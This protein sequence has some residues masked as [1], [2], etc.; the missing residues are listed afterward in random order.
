MKALIGCTGFVGSN[1]QKQSNFEYKYDSAN[2]QY[3]KGKRFDKIYCAGA[4]GNMF[5]ANR[6][7]KEDKKKIEN[8]IRNLSKIKTRKFILIS[9]IAIFDNN[10]MVNED[11]IN[12]S[13]NSYYGENRLSLERFCVENFKEC[14][15]VRLPS[16]F[17][18]GLKKNFLFDIINPVPTYLT[19]NSY[20]KIYSKLQSSLRDILD[21]IYCYND[22][23]HLFEINRDCLLFLKNKSI[24]EKMFNEINLSAVTFTAPASRFQYYDLNNLYHDICKCIDAGLK[25]IHFAPAPILASKIYFKVTGIEMPNG[26][27]KTYTEN[28]YT[29]HSSLWKKTNSYIESETK[30]LEKIKIFII[31]KKSD[32]L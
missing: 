12:I 29:L 21:K 1:L 19:L 7:P 3:A 22:K 5:L 15:I 31:E 20:K 18:Y 13:P 4:P 17:G 30:I 9:T 6:F 26:G 11:T 10:N 16:L 23:T 27:A 28:M 32:N 25:I 24:L 14:L 2:L 8:L